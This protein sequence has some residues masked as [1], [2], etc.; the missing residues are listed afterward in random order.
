MDVLKSGRSTNITYGKV[1][2]KLHLNARISIGER[3]LVTSEWVI[4]SGRN[5]PFMRAGDSGSA[6]C[7]CPEDGQTAVGVVGIMFGGSVGSQAN[8][9]FFMPATTVAN[10]LLQLTGEYLQPHHT[11]RT[12]RTIHCPAYYL[13]HIRSII[14]IH[15]LH[16]VPDHQRMNRRG[17]CRQ[18]NH[19]I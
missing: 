4:I 11:S 15:Q 13:H 12:S 9:T 8:V 3:I 19:Q 6:V 10:G 5:R 14:S 2:G 1:L 17:W 16:S 18:L 7:R